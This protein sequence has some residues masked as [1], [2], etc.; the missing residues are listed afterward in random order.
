MAAVVRVGSRLLLGML[1]GIASFAFGA[2]ALR[3]NVEGRLDR[4]ADSIYVNAVKYQELETRC[5]ELQSVYYEQCSRIDLLEEQYARSGDIL[6][7]LYEHET[8][9]EWSGVR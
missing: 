2:G 1:V 9:Q 6:E 5:V 7:A 3:A 8:G 4:Q